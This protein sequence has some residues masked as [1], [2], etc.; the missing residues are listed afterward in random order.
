MVRV[1][2]QVEID[3][4]ALKDVNSYEEADFVSAVENYK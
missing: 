3:T 4:S 2:A 1:I